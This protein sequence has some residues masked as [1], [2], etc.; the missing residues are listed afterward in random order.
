MSILTSKRN[1]FPFLNNTLYIKNR[2]SRR[3]Q[4]IDMTFTYRKLHHIE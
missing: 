2:C 4:R 1:Y 3:I